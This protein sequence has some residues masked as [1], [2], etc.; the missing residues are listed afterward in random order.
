MQERGHHYKRTRG[1]LDDLARHVKAGGYMPL[2]EQEK[3]I[4]Q[5]PISIDDVVVHR[6]QVTTETKNITPAAPMTP[7]QVAR[8]ILEGK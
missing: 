7:A 3:Q 4:G 8:M 5:L 6:P 1:L 2:N